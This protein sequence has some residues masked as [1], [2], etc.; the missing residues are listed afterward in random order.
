MLADMAAD[1]RASTLRNL[2]IKAKQAYY[3]GGEPIMEDRE[4]DA[5]EDELRLLHPDDAVL[6]IVGAPVP[7]DSMLQKAVHR[8]SMGSQS[9]VNSAEEFLTWY[10]KSCPG[11]AVNVSLKGDG[12]SAAAYYDGGVL[13]QVVSRGDG[14]V[15]EDITANASKFKGLPV[16]LPEPFSGAIRLE[17]IL[18]VDDWGIVDPLRSKNP[19]NAGSGIMGRKNGRQAEL[20]T[21]FAFDIDETTNGGLRGFRTETEKLERLVELGV[22]TIGSRLCLSPAQTVAYYEEIAKKRSELPIWIDGIVIKVD[23]LAIQTS[24]GATAGKPKGQIAWKFDSAG[25]ESRLISV[26][27]TGGHTG[28]LIPVA[29]LEPVEIGGT[30][31]K[32]ASLANWDE[33]RRLGLSIGDFVWVIKANDIIPKVISVTKKSESPLPINVPECCPFCDGPVGRRVNSGGDEGV[34]VECQ[35]EDCPKKSIGKLKRWIKSVDMQGI[36]DSVRHALVEQMGIEDAA[37]L[38]TLVHHRRALADLVIN[39]EKDLRL[40]EKRADTIIEG[41]EAKRSLSL[42]LFLGSLGID[43]LGTRRVQLLVA[44]AGGRLN[45]LSDFQC[46]L[47]REPSFAE[48]VGVPNTGAALQDGID[49]MR[50]LI[51]AL[52]AAGVVVQDATVSLEDSDKIAD[53]ETVCISGKLPSG[54]KKSDYKEALLNSGY[55]LVDQV[56][57]GLTY[58]VL[59]DPSSMSSKAAKARKLAIQIISEEELEGLIQGR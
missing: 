8:I 57:L 55:L 41:I 1:Y 25:A 18:T 47:L 10:N 22:N 29:D 23:D 36:G 33:V 34:I 53:L 46:G 30:T 16:V 37:G 31:V 21:C 13:T 15:G 32:S 42:E 6:S 51:L 45:R 9:K 11:Q 14:Q 38:Y 5:L 4:Y 3:Y 39:V 28:A 35:N 48:E 7:P 17:V 52:L 59:A 50:D 24:L 26:S 56:K 43:R 54:K 44:A 12:A 20:L 49:E 27:I 40:G 58:L 19:R 2:I